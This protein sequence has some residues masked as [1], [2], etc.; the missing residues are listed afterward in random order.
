MGGVG[1][2]GSMGSNEAMFRAA[3]H[4]SSMGQFKA[5][6]MLL[7]PFHVVHKALIPHGHLSEIAQK[8]QI[9]IDLDN[10]MAPQQCQLTFSG[11]MVAN[12]LASYFLQERA[13]QYCAD[14]S[15]QQ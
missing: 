10:E 9:K 13:M 1:M 5:Q 3:L 11:S 4:Q 15:F 12:S 6:L 7:L 2:M 8:C 14:P